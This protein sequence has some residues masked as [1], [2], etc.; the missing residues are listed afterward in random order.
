MEKEAQLKRGLAHCPRR[1]QK[2]KLVFSS[3]F[4]LFLP[5]CI[6]TLLKFRSWQSVPLLASC[7]SANLTFGVAC[8]SNRSGIYTRPGRIKLH[9]PRD[10]SLGLRN[11]VRFV[12]TAV[13]SLHCQR[14]GK[15]ITDKQRMDLR[16]G[17]A[18]TEQVH[19][20]CFSS[21]LHLFLLS[22][23]GIYY[24]TG[25]IPQAVNYH[26]AGR[27]KS[28]CLISGLCVCLHEPVFYM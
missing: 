17:Y 5:L 24:R 1:F 7:F 10:R 16:Q 9:V 18:L 2:R 11:T 13:Q 3:W 4:H 19:F 14:Q 28:S 22:L 20:Y 27:D 12:P 21:P 26:T 25:Y 15:S 23:N 8:N 6:L